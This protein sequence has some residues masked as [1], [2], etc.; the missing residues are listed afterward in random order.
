MNKILLENNT[1]FDKLET[2]KKGLKHFAFSVFLFNEKNE[3]LIQKRSKNKYHSN[4]LWSNTCCSHFKSLEE[5]NNIEETIKNRIFEELG[6][7]YNEKIQQLTIYN[8]NENVTDDLIENEIDYIFIGKIN[9]NVVFNLNKEEV[10][11][12]KFLNFEKLVK[13]INKNN[14]TIWFYKILN[15]KDLINKIYDYLNII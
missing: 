7:K 3:L 1:L 6:L 14:Y 2:H 8:Y 9:N 4:G 13:E 11:E 12:I 10:E 15:N 5:K